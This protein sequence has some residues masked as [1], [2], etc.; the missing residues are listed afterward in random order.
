MEKRAQKYSHT[1]DQLCDKIGKKQT[2]EQSLFN[3]W[4]WK[5]EQLYRKE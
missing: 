5:S 4:Y 1:F 2:M 3:K